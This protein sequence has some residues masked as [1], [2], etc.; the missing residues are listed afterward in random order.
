[1]FTEFEWLARLELIIRAPAQRLLYVCIHSETLRHSQV[2]PSWKYYIYSKGIFCFSSR[3]LCRVQPSDVGQEDD[4]ALRY[5][6]PLSALRVYQTVES[7]AFEYQHHH[8]GRE[9]RERR[10]LNQ[11]RF[12]IGVV[13]DGRSIINEA[14]GF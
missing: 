10:Q 8:L 7:S 13:S 4:V 9:V 5:I 11:S 12:L 6:S 1:M 2:H 14:G 3:R